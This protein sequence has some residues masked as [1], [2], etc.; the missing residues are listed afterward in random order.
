[1]RGGRSLV[2]L[3]VVAL[4]LGA[5]IYFVE[6]KRDPLATDPHEKV[7][8]VEADA[9]ERMEIRS[10]GGETTTLEKSNGTWRLT[11]PVVAEADAAAVRSIADSIATADIV[12]VLEEN[13]GPVAQYGLEPARISVAFRKSGDATEYRLNLGEKTP[14]NGEIYAQVA[15]QPRLL[16]LGGFIEDTF[17]RTAFDL[18][19]KSVL[20]FDRDAVD[21]ITLERPAEPRIEL[22][23]EGTDWKLTAPLQTR[24]DSSPVDGILARLEQAQMSSIAHEGGEPTP[25][26]LQTLGLDRPRLVATFG[27]GSTRAALA[28]GADKDANTVYAR[29]LSRPL[30]FTVEKS[31]LTDLQKQPADLRV[32]DVFAFK[33]YTAV[34]IELTHAGTSA[35]FEKQP[36]TEAAGGPDVWKQTRPQT[37]DANAT[38]M[39]D[40]LNTLSS[41]RAESFVA[42][43]PAKGEDMVV[44]A[45]YG[46][47]DAPTEERV[48]LR[49]A[50]TSVYAITPDEP[51]AAVVPAAN[52][53]T[54]VTQFKAVTGA[55]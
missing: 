43:A 44:V 16:L 52:F 47:A 30:V 15:G 2:A 40:L 34:G 8:A 46:N 35:A 42:Q 33:S 45:R 9:I 10:A 12:A 28:I 48:T 26:Q 29:D 32:K 5:Y 31:L 24:A 17:N 22:A 14:V 13:P 27:A 19:D 54:A 50:G 51:G 21:R 11:S 23:R 7:F 38:A 36:T 4:G 39:A 6:S 49:K 18:R 37:K 55:E 53:D 25:A 20:A 1:M 3:L 41:L